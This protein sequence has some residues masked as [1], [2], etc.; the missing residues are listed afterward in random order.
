MLPPF[1]TKSFIR[2]ASV[3]SFVGL[4]IYGRVF[5]FVGFV[6]RL[7]SSRMVAGSAS[8]FFWRHLT[9]RT[10]VGFDPV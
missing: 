4:G 8:Q 5:A 10:G 1:D 6:S 9:F 3:S 7:L 2:V